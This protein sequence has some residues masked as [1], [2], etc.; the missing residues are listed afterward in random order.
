VATQADV[1]KIALSLPGVV[2]ADKGFAF[3]ARKL[4]P[5]IEGAWRCEASSDLRLLRHRPG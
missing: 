3:S 1:R 2:Q 4:A 5:L